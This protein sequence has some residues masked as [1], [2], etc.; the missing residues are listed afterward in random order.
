[1]KPL[2][3]G[4]D[5]VMAGRF[6]LWL[7]GQRSHRRSLRRTA[8]ASRVP[9]RGLAQRWLT[10]MAPWT[11]EEYPGRIQLLAEICGVSRSRV[12]DWL[13]RTKPGKGLPAKHARRLMVLCEERA[14]ALDAL[15]S[16]LRRHADEEDWLAVPKGIIRYQAEARDRVDV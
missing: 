4:L 14:A 3:P 2:P 7:L 6:G 5:P 1:M 8:S 9:G 11:I 12:G 15:A 13:Y 16:D 10:L